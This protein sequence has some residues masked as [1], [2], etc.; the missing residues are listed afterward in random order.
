[1]IELNGTVKSFTV[2]SST[3]IFRHAINSKAYS[4]ELLLRIKWT[5]FIIQT[6]IDSSIFFINE[7]LEEILLGTSCSLEILRITKHAIGS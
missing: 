1:M 5:T 4:I 3:R 6:P 2:T 7:M